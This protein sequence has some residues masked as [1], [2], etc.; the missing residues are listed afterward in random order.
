M[1]KNMKSAFLVNHSPKLN[2]FAYTSNLQYNTY[3]KIFFYMACN[4]NICIEEGI[5]YGYNMCSFCRLD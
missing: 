1:R 4:I 3:K 2:Y 5:C